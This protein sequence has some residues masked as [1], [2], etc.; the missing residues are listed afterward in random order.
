MDATLKHLLAEKAQ[1]KLLMAAPSESIAD[2]VEIMNEHKVGAI[3]IMKDG[4]LAGIFT[5]RDVLQKVIGKVKDSHK[6]AVSEVMTK[7]PI[8]VS[9]EMS[10]SQAMYLV[11]EK[12]FRHLPVV[13]DGK[14]LGLISSGDLTRWVVNNQQIEIRDLHNYITG[15]H[16]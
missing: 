14:V 15:D 2:C 16:Y 10:V 8:T 7:D 5:E 4:K 1:Q 9:P 11:T 6:M 12:R 13:A 3:L